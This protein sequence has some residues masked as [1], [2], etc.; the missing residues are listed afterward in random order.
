[1]AN[2]FTLEFDG[3]YQIVTNGNSLLKAAEPSIG[4]PLYIGDSN[5]QAVKLGDV[6]ISKMYIGDTLIY[7]T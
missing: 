1:M 5:I 2:N 4:L 6:N 3:Q 7:G